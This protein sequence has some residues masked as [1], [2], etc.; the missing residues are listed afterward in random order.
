MVDKSRT[1]F[2]EF[3]KTTPHNLTGSIAAPENPGAAQLCYPACMV[4][5]SNMRAKMPL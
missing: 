2:E 1:N 5:F 4:I 3:V